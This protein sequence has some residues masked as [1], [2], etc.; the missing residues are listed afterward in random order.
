MSTGRRTHQPSHKSGD[1]QLSST[2]F[3]NTQG[4]N[5]I[6]EFSGTN[7]Y[8]LFESVS[9]AIFLLDEDKIV[10][11]NNKTW[12]M[13][14]CDSG[15]IINQ[16]LTKYLPP[17]QPDG[18]DSR[19]KIKQIIKSGQVKWTMETVTSVYF[20]GKRGVLGNYVDINDRKN[21]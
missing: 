8:P 2:S 6:N 12:E 15:H 1:N 4:S 11:C 9:D 5:G 10:D 7:F 17:K 3:K 14:A 19:E 21:Y 18:A 16:S 20:D 13:F